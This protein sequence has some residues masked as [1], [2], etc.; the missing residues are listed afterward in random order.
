MLDVQSGR[1]S[2]IKD[3]TNEDAI[4]RIRQVLSEILS[5]VVRSQFVGQAGLRITVRHGGVHKLHKRW[6]TKGLGGEPLRNAERNRDA[7]SGA[8]DTLQWMLLQTLVKGFHG[9]ATLT[10]EVEN[11]II[12]DVVA[13]IEESVATGT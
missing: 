13:E 10:L 7:S 8:R 5:K 4:H 1:Q 12:V 2:R 9:E 3:R 11:G 6:R